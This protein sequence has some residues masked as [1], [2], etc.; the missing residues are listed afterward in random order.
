MHR[1][2]ERCQFSQ[3]ICFTRTKLLLH[4]LMI[5]INNDS[6]AGANWNCGNFS[7]QFNYEMIRL[8][9]AKTTTHCIWQQHEHALVIVDMFGESGMYLQQREV[10]LYS[11]KNETE[12][13]KTRP[14]VL[15]SL[16][17]PRYKN[18]T[19]L[20]LFHHNLKNWRCI[21]LNIDNSLY[22]LMAISHRMHITTTHVFGTYAAWLR[23][24]IIWHSFWLRLA[25][26]SPL[27]KTVISVAFRQDQSYPP[28]DMYT[29]LPK[30]NVTQTF[31]LIEWG[32]SRQ[33]SKSERN[34]TSELMFWKTLDFVT[35]TKAR[36]N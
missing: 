25:F 10:I 24:N 35:V 22:Q 1:W 29:V 34:S 8:M 9:T 17:G 31:K 6:T 4:T 19:V 30:Q 3:Q 15:D 21:I 2:Q 20:P 5:R 7:V 33:N 12:L 28:T 13:V 32:V 23:K 26:C 18:W 27:G 14:Q 16:L 36:N 11:L